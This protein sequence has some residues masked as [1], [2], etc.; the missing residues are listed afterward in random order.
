MTKFDKLRAEIDKLE[1]QDQIKQNMVAK[2]KKIMLE[3]IENM[4]LYGELDFNC[5]GTVSGRFNV[6]D[7]NDNRIHNR[8]LLWNCRDNRMTYGYPIKVLRQL[9]GSSY[10]IIGFIDTHGDRWDK[11]ERRL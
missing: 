3:R 4:K 9:I 5:C 7:T 8:C 11:A 10:K 2:D 1:E 6:G